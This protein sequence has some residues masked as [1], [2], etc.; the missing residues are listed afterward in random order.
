M[1]LAVR[2]VESLDEALEHIARHGSGHSEAIVTGSLEAATRFHEEVDA[3]AV[4]VDASTR[5]TD[6]AEF[7]M[8]PRSASPPRSCTR[9]GRSASPS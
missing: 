9:G 1:V 4:Y 7:G 5:F 8:E 2:V 3:A 6:G